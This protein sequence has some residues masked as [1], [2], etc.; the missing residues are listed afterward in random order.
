MLRI[1]HCLDNRLTDDGEVISPTY[2]PRSTP[3]KQFPASGTHF[4]LYA[5][6]DTNFADKRRSDGMAR[7]PTKATE[8]AFGTHFC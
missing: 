1:P 2:R 8:F 4:P 5:K 3:Q 7:S 6:V